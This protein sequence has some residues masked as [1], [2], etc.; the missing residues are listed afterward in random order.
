M[1]VDWTTFA[2]EIINFLILVW[3]LKRFFYHPVLDVIAR[4][5]AGI[6]KEMADAKAVE[7]KAQALEQ[8][9]ENRLA[10]WEKE[11]E[12]ARAKLGEEISRERE[13]QMAA[14]AAAVE[15][16][17]ERNRVLDERH[18]QELRRTAEEQAL[19]QGAAFSARVL[20]R[21]ADAGLD[22]RIVETMVA[23]LQRLTLEQRQTLATSAA[24]AGV[25]MHIVT[26]RPLRDAAQ[27]RLSAAM[28]EVLQRALP[29]EYAIDESLI[30]GVRVTIGPW[31]LHANL[32]DDLQFFA[33][34][35][36]R[37]S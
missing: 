22:E 32:S 17:R 34:G 26:A 5:R 20:S 31:V 29:Q 11:R 28:T 7:E 24:E 15:A 37:A 18:R 2:L 6:E 35:V 8:Q 9:Y 30:G 14:V 13:H 23:D 10:D 19:A 27:A 33:G 21:L 16:E 25:K 3:I 1:E 12:G 36:R 4:R